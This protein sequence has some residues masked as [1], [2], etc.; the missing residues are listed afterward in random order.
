MEARARRAVKRHGWS[1]RKSRKRTPTIDD[2]ASSGVEAAQ[3]IAGKADSRTTKPYNRRGQKRTTFYSKNRVLC[4]FGNSKFEHGFG[5]NPD[6]LLR[7]GIKARARPPLLFYQL[8]KAGQDKLAVLFGR[9]VSESAERIEEYSSGLL[10]GLALL[11][12]E[13]VQVLF[14]PSLGVVYDSH[15]GT[16]SRTSYLLCSIPS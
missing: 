2:Q 10:I 4:H 11:Q 6:L 14:W 13:R 12:Q 8:A 7:V 15:T 5:R 16:L 3:R 9:F 1:L